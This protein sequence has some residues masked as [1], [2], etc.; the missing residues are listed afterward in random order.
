MARI[1]P[2]VENDNLN[3]ASSTEPTTLT[4]WHKS[5]LFNCKGFAVYNSNGDLVFRVDNYCSN[6][7][8]E[9]VLMDAI[10]ND[11]LL[12]RHKRFSLG[13]QWQGF[14]QDKLIFS[15]KKSASCWC[16]GKQKKKMLAEVYMNGSKYPDFYVEGSFSKR[17]CTFYNSEGTIITEVRRK[18][19]A[20]NVLLGA[21][22][23]TM[24]VQRGYNLSLSMGY[25]IVLERLHSTPSLLSQWFGA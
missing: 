20:P 1:R 11:I 7:S 17:S 22:V 6:R 18:Q 9:I 10:G 19:G 14:Q 21:D 25:L 15:M 5:L 16:W 2:T 12:L 24:T 8:R 23:F 4:V 3:I 13:K